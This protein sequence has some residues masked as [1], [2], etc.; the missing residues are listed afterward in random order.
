[1]VAAAV[2]MS[3]APRRRPGSG[4]GDGLPAGLLSYSEFVD[5]ALFDPTWGY[6]STGGVRFGEGGHY[7]TY[8]LALSPLFG[9]MVAR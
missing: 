8:P 3:P 9:R 7:D 5:L 6:Y 4:A 2:A 1:M